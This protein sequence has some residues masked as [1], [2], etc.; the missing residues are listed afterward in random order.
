MKIAVFLGPTLPAAEAR[1]AL[2]DVDVLP[3]AK[4]GD[5]YRAAKDG[6][7]IIGL[8]DGYF[9]Q[10]NSV[11]HKEVLWA[12]SHGVHV[13]GAASMG[14]LRAVELAAFG[15]EGVGAVFAQFARGALVDDDEV[16]VLHAPAEEGYR[17]ASEAMVDIRATLAAARA[18]GV[19]G[20]DTHARLVRAAKGLFYPDRA[21]P[22]VLARA[23]ADGTAQSELHALRAFLPGGR[24]E[25]KRLDALALLDRLRALRDAAPGPKVVRFTF[26]HTDAWEAIR[27]RADDPGS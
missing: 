21:Y 8:V 27:R 5:L 13:L 6:A 12:M 1:A 15:M 24:V 25:Q 17:R 2:D 3:P 4:Q 11:A 18:A 16:A 20:E 9:D 26:A 19:I 23:E 22:L 10:V 14:A 7:A